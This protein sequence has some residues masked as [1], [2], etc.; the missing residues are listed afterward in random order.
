[1]FD[2][3]SYKTIFFLIDPHDP[4]PSGP[5]PRGHIKNPKVLCTSPYRYFYFVPKFQVPI[6]NGVGGVT[7]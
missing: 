5:A 3:K 7:G 4:N 6:S 1:M 2:L